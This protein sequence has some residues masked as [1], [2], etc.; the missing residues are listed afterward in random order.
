[1]ASWYSSFALDPYF[2]V[3]VKLKDEWETFL[4]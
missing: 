4:I 2:Y 3:N 1:M